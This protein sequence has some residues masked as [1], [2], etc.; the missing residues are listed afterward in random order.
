[1]FNSV[2]T[3]LKLTKDVVNAVSVCQRQRQQF[4][5]KK[6]WHLSDDCSDEMKESWWII[7]IF[8]LLELERFIILALLMTWRGRL[9]PLVSLSSLS[10]S[11]FCNKWTLLRW[12]VACGG[13][14]RTIT[15][16]HAVGTW[17]LNP[18]DNKQRQQTVKCKVKCKC[19]KRNIHMDMCL[20]S[21][22]RQMILLLFVLQLQRIYIMSNTC[23]TNWS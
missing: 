22:H 10:L 12:S 13:R 15:I 20:L 6:K 3:A 8:I 11:T 4:E 17:P 18:C 5:L 9:K 23:V 16:T 19:Y 7:C 1:M 14:D 21:S 2:D